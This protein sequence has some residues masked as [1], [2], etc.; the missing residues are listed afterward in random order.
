ML[1]SVQS[2][3]PRRRGR[4]QPSPCRTIRPTNSNRPLNKLYTMPI[5]I[6][7]PPLT[8]TSCFYPTRNGNRAPYQHYEKRH[9][10]GIPYPLPRPPH[11]YTIRPMAIGSLRTQPIQ[12][13][14]AS[15]TPHCQHH[16]RSRTRQA[17]HYYI[18]MTLPRVS[19]RHPKPS[20]MPVWK[21]GTRYNAQWARKNSTH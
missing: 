13:T 10:K 21:N 2:P 7:T 18:K 9:G 20:M 5:H 16:Q 11:P 19:G 14:H 8:A 4:E 1:A 17:P 12:A 6:D 15:H 3:T